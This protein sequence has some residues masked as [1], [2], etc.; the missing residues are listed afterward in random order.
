MMTKCSLLALL[1]G[2]SQILATGASEPRGAQKP[3]AE[4]GWLTAAEAQK[5]FD[6]LRRVLEEAH[7]GLYEVVFSESR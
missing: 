6:F 2:L 5:D 1:T 3:E 7:P 4:A